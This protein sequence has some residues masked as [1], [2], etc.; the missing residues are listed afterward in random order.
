MR[1]LDR[2]RV[3]GKGDAVG[4]YELAGMRDAL[5]DERLDLLR[6]FETGIEQYKNREWDRAKETFEEVLRRSPQ[7]GPSVLYLKR[8]AALLDNPPGPEWEPVTTFTTK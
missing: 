3:K 7:D 1:E 4:I 2:V 8:V 6:I 5:G